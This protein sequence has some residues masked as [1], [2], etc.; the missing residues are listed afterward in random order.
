MF[1]VAVRS[2]G[3]QARCWWVQTTVLSGVRC[4]VLSPEL[5]SVLQGC[6]LVTSGFSL[7]LGNVFPS[8]MDYLRCAAG[9]VS[10]VIG[11]VSGMKFADVHLGLC[12]GSDA[13]LSLPLVQSL[14][15]GLQLQWDQ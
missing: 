8:E 11:S 14:L 5:A 2:G 1:C 13:L 4:A 12:C 7:Y 9:S 6:L 3:I 15:T 10:G